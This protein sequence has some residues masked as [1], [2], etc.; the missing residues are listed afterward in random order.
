MALNFSFVPLVYFAYP[1]TANLTLEEIDW[2]FVEPDAVKMSRQVAR[3][4]WGQEAL[5]RRRSAATLVGAPTVSGA[6]AEKGT[7]QMRE[8]V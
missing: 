5:K 4:G 7:Q 3:H 6:K 2:L 1:E 8:V